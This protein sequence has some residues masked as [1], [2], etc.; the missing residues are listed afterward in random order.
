MTKNKILILSILSF[1][2]LSFSFYWFSYKPESIRKTCAKEN[3]TY[4]DG[5]MRDRFE[6]CLLRNG[7]TIK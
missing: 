3:T 2:L 7:L 1:I 4:V 5:L 6:N